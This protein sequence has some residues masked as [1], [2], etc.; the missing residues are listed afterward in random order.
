MELAFVLFLIAALVN[1]KPTKAYDQQRLR[2][3]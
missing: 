1:I 3:Q 2:K